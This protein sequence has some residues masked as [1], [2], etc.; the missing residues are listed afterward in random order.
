[1][2]TC[3][4]CG[5]TDPAAWADCPGCG[6]PQPTPAAYPPVDQTPPP[7]GYGGAYPPQ[8]QNPYA[9]P[10]SPH[11][12]PAAYG[13]AYSQPL[14][15]PTSGKAVTSLVLGICS[16]VIP[17]IGVILGPI[18]IAFW[19]ASR[20]D[21]RHNPPLYKGAGLSTAG[22]IC[23]IIGTLLWL[24]VFVMIFVIVTSM[25]SASRHDGF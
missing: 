14:M 6:Q 23:G 5:Y 2:S 9:P 24:L 10:T 4:H 19:G 22:L 18:A 13:Y 1:M 12:L 25:K 21:F 7:V 17:Y 11:A 3:P 15:L 20:G 16:I 8:G